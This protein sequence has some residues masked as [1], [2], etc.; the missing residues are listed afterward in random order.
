MDKIKKQLTNNVD[1][2]KKQAIRYNKNN[3]NSQYK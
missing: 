1:I 3:S 2:V